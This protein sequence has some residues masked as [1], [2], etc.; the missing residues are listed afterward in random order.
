MCAVGRKLSEERTSAEERA[1]EV[2][3]KLSDLISRINGMIHIDVT[4]MQTTYSA[5]QTLSA[6]SSLPCV[7][8]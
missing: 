1:A 4:D 3:R 2:E 5:E 6:V 7:V 8:N